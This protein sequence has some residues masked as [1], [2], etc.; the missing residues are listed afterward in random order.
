MQEWSF[1]IKAET[2]ADL[3]DELEAAAAF[4]RAFPSMF[5]HAPVDFQIE[6]TDTSSANRVE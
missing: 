5:S 6:V 2:V 1:I 3:C 4:V